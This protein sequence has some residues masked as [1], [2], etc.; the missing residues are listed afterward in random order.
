MAQL[1]RFLSSS[2]RLPACHGGLSACLHTHT[3][4]HICTYMNVA[5]AV[6]TYMMASRRA[7]SGWGCRVLLHR[8]G[9]PQPQTRRRAAA[10][11]GSRRDGTLI[12]ATSQVLL[13][14]PHL[15]P[16]LPLHDA[17]EG[18]SD[19]SRMRVAVWLVVGD[20]QIRA[21]QSPSSFGLPI[22]FL[23]S[24]ATLAQVKVTNN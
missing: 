22:T 20:L 2:P 15:R 9:R 13:P 7:S 16:S 8:L 3:H 5:A 4:T 18:N 17:V 21:W 19:D 24:R 23:A 12:G 14:S 1:E 10:E 6:Q 11:H